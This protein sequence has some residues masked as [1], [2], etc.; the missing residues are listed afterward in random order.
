MKTPA[1]LLLAACVFACAL[2]PAATQAAVPSKLAY[3]TGLAGTHPQVHVANGDG[4]GAIALGSGVDAQISPDGANVAIVTTYTRKGTAL[5][6]RPAAGGAARTLATTIDSLGPIAWSP[7]GA[8]LSVVINTRRLVVI[9]V[10]SGARR[11]VGLDGT[12]GETVAEHGWPPLA[13]PP[14]T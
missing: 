6:V 4:S 9:D 5:V 13:S 11:L 3:V 1:S 2:A 7:D 8:L 14:T 10:A 12:I